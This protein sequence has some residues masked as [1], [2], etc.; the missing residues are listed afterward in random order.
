MNCSSLFSHWL[1]V[2][3]SASDWSDRPV[4]VLMATRNRTSSR[5]LIVPRCQR[6]NVTPLHLFSFSPIAIEQV[7]LSHST[8][9]YDEVKFD[10]LPLALRRF[11]RSTGNSVWNLWLAP[12]AFAWL[13][14]DG[15]ETILCFGHHC[16]TRKETDDK[17]NRLAGH[18]TWHS[19]RSHCIRHVWQRHVPV[20][21]SSKKISYLRS[22]DR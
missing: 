5:S 6:R 11:H 13:S 17:R 21:F 16:V 18:F 14:P 20:W 4:I 19:F 2:D 10:S 3:R 12:L 15:Y 1:A 8:K 9:Q 7:A 22:T